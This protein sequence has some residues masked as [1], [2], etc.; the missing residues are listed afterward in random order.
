MSGS[1]EPEGECSQ[2][3]CC[4]APQGRDAKCVQLGLEL[5]RVPATGNHRILWLPRFQTINAIIPTAAR[6]GAVGTWEGLICQAQRKECVNSCGIVS[7][8]GQEAVSDWG[9]PARG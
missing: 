8:E 3:C 4:G 1:E 9:H 6:E 7:G 5:G 2:L